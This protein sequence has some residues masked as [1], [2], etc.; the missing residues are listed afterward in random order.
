M[1]SRIKAIVVS[2][3]DT[4]NEKNDHSGERLLQLL[5]DSGAEVLE[6]Q[7]VTDDFESLRQTLYSLTETEANLVLTTGGTGFSPRDNTP[8]ATLAV[9]DREAPGISEALRIE[10]SKHTK[11]AMLSRGVAGIRN[12]TLL[13]NLPGSLKGVEECFE[14]ISPIMEH[15]VELLGGPVSHE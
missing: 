6:K 9:I 7:L 3:S 12:G 15:A 2:V 4:R 13:I 14:V 10:S 8:E 5:R 1:E 11:F